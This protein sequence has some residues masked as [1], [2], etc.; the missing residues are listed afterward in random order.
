MK[1]LVLC[2][3]ICGSLLWMNPQ[4]L[5]LGAGAAPV[6]AVGLGAL[7]FYNFKVAGSPWLLPYFVHDGQYAAIG[8][9][10]LQHPKAPLPVYRHPEFRRLFA[11]WFVRDALAY[12]A[13]PVSKLSFLW[14]FYFTKWPLI[15]ALVC[16]VFAVKNRRLRWASMLLAVFFASVCML[17]G[18]LPHYAAPGVG[19]LLLFEV[20]GLHLAAVL[21]SAGQAVGESAGAG[22]DLNDS[23]VVCAGR[24]SEAAVLHFGPSDIQGAAQEFARAIECGSWKT[25][26]AGALLGGAQSVYGL[27]SER[28]GVRAGPHSMGA[29]HGS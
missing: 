9:F 17:T 1:G 24:D 21:E 13:H 28:R 11:E 23:D 4:R 15:L 14:G 8:N 29:R 6:V 7:L 2:A 18:I 27:R 19:L 22:G 5:A 16:G 12:G 20:G 10:I 3:L 25:T 26:G